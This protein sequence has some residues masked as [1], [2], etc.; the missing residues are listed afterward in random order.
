MPENI[1]EPSQLSEGP[2]T[3][4]QRYLYACTDKYMTFEEF[5][6]QNNKMDKERVAKLDKTNPVVFKGKFRIDSQYV[7]LYKRDGR[8]WHCFFDSCDSHGDYG[9]ITLEEALEKISDPDITKEV[10][11]INNGEER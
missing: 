4:Y 5:Q 2:L 6:V 1:L 8:D 11:G 9:K 7:S 10:L 3:R